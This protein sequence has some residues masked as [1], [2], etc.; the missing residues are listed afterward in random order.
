MDTFN[1]V[2]VQS[3]T[4]N[5]P[6]TGSTPH[7]LLRNRKAIV[8]DDMGAAVVIARNM[9]V[10]LGAKLV[11][12]A[13]DYA[14]AFTK[15]ARKPYDLILCDFNLG[16]GL[17]GQ[18][19]LRDLRHVGRLSYTT[20]FVV[21]SAERTRD[22]VLGTIECEPDGY[23]AKPFTQGEFKLRIARLVEQQNMLS[24]FNKAL[25]ARDYTRAFSE[26]DHIIDSEPRYASLALKRKAG[27][28]YEI[29]AFDE[30]KALFDKA[31]QKHNG[32]TW[33]KIG[34]ARC[35]AESGD[36]GKAIA[37]FEQII[38][39]HKLAVPAIDSLATCHLRNGNKRAALQALTQS[40]ELSPMSTERQRWHGDLCF[41]TGEM[42]S[43]MKAYQTVIKLATGT[44]KENP[45]QYENY[46]KALRKAVESSTDNKLAME[47]IA[48]GKK[49]VKTSLKKFE[50][51]ELLRL[52]QTLIRA[53][54]KVK[55]GD[56][57]ESIAIIDAALE[58]HKAMLSENPEVVIDLAETKFFA[59]DRPGAE[60][61]LVAL[62][63]KYADNPQ[64]VE[65]IQAIIDTP[66]PYHKRVLI[67]ELNRRG[68]LCYERQDYD[69][70]L[71]HFNHALQEYPQH[72]A[73]NMNAVQVMLKMIEAGQ[74]NRGC[75]QEA[76]RYLDASVS[77][78]PEHPE[79]TRK[80]AFTKY[81]RKQLA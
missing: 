8:I 69:E 11:D 58:R 28:L 39:E 66:L 35:I 62:K 21:V 12:T 18:Q 52:N 78:E 71:K 41:D 3:S 64:L 67:T 51:A 2:N 4:Q 15:I 73:I 68:K 76:Q 23:I 79:Y 59:D 9:L 7:D 54:E 30:A 65:R 36:T 16:A 14:S 60:A 19:L 57:E 37:E 55:L 29:K 10:S 24:S 48:D 20:L 26:A 53:L 22:I 34:R 25:D 17:N 61:L 47:L 32:Q 31:L 27:V 13:Q 70:A 43:A 1:A 74:L 72:P 44:L 5:K 40:L 50:D 6:G 81:L 45:V 38:A 77:L 42:D 75:F 33:A 80:Q 49:V 46:L 63:E 56:N